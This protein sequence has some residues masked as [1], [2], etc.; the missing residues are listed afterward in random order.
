MAT[1]QELLQELEQEAPATRRVLARVPADKFAWRPHERS[2]SMGQL[3]NHLAG[4]PRNIVFAVL[5]GSFDPGALPPTMPPASAEALLET[6]DSA[7]EYARAE[8]GRMS[9]ADLGIPWNVM[10]G[11]KVAL[12]MPRGTALRMVLLNHSYHHRGQLTVYLRLNGIPLPSVY[13]PTADE[14]PFGM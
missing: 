12:S 10:R 14:P 1:V 2:M 4:L 3:A 8:L 6:F 7:M 11:E 9:D 5:Q 13:G